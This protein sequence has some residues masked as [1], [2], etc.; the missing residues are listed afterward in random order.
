[1]WTFTQFQINSADFLLEKAMLSRFFSILDSSSYCAQ[2]LGNLHEGR[3]SRHQGILLFT[4]GWMGASGSPHKYNLVHW[5]VWCGNLRTQLWLKHKP[6]CQA[7]MIRGRMSTMDSNHAT[8]KQI[9]GSQSRAWHL[10]SRISTSWS[11]IISSVWQKWLICGKCDKDST[12]MPLVKPHVSTAFGSQSR[13]QHTSG[14]PRWIH[15]FVHV[16]PQ[17]K[18]IVKSWL[19]SP[20][21]RRGGC[22]WLTV[23]WPWTNNNWIHLDVSQ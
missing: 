8:R 10:S 7:L 22:S 4:H 17:K 11:A 20:R 16:E 13:G 2:G 23:S 3:S 15:V 12:N 19:C 5:R 9:T 18:I 14:C 6:R 21:V 1:M